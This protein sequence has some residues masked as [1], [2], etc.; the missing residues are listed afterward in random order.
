MVAGRWSS[1][2]LFLQ[3]GGMILRGGRGEME[4]RRRGT[5]SSRYGR[6]FLAVMT[7]IKRIAE[8]P[9]RQEIRSEEGEGMTWA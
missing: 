6:R 9:A 4:G 2:E 5:C 7:G 3:P 8:S 1:G